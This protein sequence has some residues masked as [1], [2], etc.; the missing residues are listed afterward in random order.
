MYDAH[1][2]PPEPS[3][4]DSVIRI[5]EAGQRVILDRFDLAYFD[6]TQLGTRTLRGAALIAIG[7]VMLTGA[8]FTLMGG[9]VVWLQQHFSLTT[10]LGIVAVVSAAVGVLALG[11]GLR[12]AQTVATAAAGEL[13]E[14][15][16]Q[17]P[18][19][20]RPAEHHVHE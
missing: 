16:R 10:S 8:W 20:A 1:T 5:F 18:A 11:I 6:L 14:S 12:R 13:V 3:L 15:V 9:V 19:P 4:L 17:R 2:T 7:A